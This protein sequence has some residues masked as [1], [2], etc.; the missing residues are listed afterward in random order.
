MPLALLLSSSLGAIQAALRLRSSS[1]S[2]ARSVPSCAAAAASPASTDKAGELL[3]TVT[4]ASTTDTTL[5][6]RDCACR[7]GGTRCVSIFTGARAGATASPA[8][9]RGCARAQLRSRCI[10]AVCSGAPGPSVRGATDAG[11]EWPSDPPPPRALLA[12]GAATVNALIA[13]RSLPGGLSQGTP[14]CC[15]GNNA[16]CFPDLPTAPGVASSSSRRRNGRDV[17]VAAR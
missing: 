11:G 6:G 5:V 15:R 12:L 10:A 7:D 14:A 13:V 1:S 9:N 3:S 2:A 8:E 17:V 4:D 16:F